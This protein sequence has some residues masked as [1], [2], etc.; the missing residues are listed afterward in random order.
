MANRL[1]AVLIEIKQES[2]DMNFVRYWVA[3]AL[4]DLAQAI[5]PR[6][7]YITVG[8]SPCGN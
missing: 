3:S 7:H 6:G 8:K 1:K 4:C 2:P 5:I